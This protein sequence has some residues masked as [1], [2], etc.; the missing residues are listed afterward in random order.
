MVALCDW[1]VSAS[2]RFV[3]SIT[4]ERFLPARSRVVRGK[5]CR[6]GF[7]TILRSAKW[8]QPKYT[9]PA[10]HLHTR[11]VGKAVNTVCE[12][13]L[14]DASGCEL[15]V[16]NRHSKLSGFC[17]LCAANMLND[18]CAR[19]ALKT[20]RNIDFRQEPQELLESSDPAWRLRIP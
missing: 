8:S 9:Q 17:I 11:G 20:P 13:F 6:S 18:D 15:I 2:S 10:R 19:R 3:L 1:S 14:D 7:P 5:W 12:R 4:A 16:A